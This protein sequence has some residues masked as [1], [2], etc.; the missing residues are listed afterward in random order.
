MFLRSTRSKLLERTVDGSD[1]AAVVLT[2]DLWQNKKTT[3]MEKYYFGS[4]FAGKWDTGCDLYDHVDFDE[5]FAAN[6][7]RSDEE[8][9]IGEDRGLDTVD[10]DG[11]DLEE[12][13]GNAIVVGGRRAAQFENLSLVDR[14]EDDGH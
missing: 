7:E 14:V 2:C 5:F 9:A 6:V 3:N 1:E 11:V 10:I 8:T 12:Y 4:F 13:G